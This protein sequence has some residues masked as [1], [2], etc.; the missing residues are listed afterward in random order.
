[1]QQLGRRNAEIHKAYRLASTNN[2]SV[3]KGALF[4]NVPEVDKRK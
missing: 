3:R 1:M 4:N 2:S